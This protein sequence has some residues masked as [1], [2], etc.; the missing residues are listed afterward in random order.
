MK[1]F[2]FLYRK[3]FWSLSLLFI[4]ELGKSISIPGFSTSVATENSQNIILNFISS[5]TGG[6]FSNP[7]LFSLGMGPYMSALIIWTAISMSNFDWIKNMSAKTRGYC[8]RAITLLFT[9]IQAT[10]LGFRFQ[11]LDGFKPLT[12][13]LNVSSTV[14]LILILIAG[15][16]I[17][18]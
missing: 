4:L 14:Q 6:S 1:N 5:S 17:I 7:S 8:Q 15:G 9:I 18:S 16:L 10:V 13:F 2:K 12:D 11:K 3:I